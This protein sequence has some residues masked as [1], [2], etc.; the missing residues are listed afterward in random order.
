MD[1]VKCI[2]W[3]IETATILKR[4]SITLIHVNEMRV[5]YISIFLWAK[6]KKRFRRFI[7][8]KKKKNKIMWSDIGSCNF[9]IPKMSVFMQYIK[10]L[11]EN[12]L[13][14]FR[15]AYFFFVCKWVRIFWW[16]YELRA[17]RFF[18][19]QFYFGSIKSWNN[20]G[21][22]SDSIRIFPVYDME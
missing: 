13:F 1:F 21:C 4:M 18:L 16:E 9:I 5:K 3:K 22:F 2:S 12:I 10:I 19:S 7:E 15:F 17:L 8:R 14:W 20:F 6:K 11:I